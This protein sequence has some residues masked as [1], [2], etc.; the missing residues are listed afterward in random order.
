VAMERGAGLG[1]ALQQGQQGPHGID[2]PT[3]WEALL[4]VPGRSRPGQWRR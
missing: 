1:G 4:T 3:T 2:R